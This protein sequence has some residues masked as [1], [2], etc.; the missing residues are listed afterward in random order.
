M[1]RA[2]PVEIGENVEIAGMAQT[3]SLG[4]PVQSVLEEV[5]GA[6]HSSHHFERREVEFGSTFLPL[7][8]DAVNAIVHSHLR[9]PFWSSASVLGW[10]AS[11]LT[12]S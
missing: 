2:G 10:L 8:D 12:Y 11:Y 3:I 1:G 9:A 4:D 7:P 6:N 5:R